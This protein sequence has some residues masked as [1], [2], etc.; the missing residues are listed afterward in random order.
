MAIH[1]S[2]LTPISDFFLLSEVM[3]MQQTGSV[4]HKLK[5]R[6]F[7]K[8]AHLW[9]HSVDFQ[10][11]INHAWHLIPLLQIL[12][13]TISHFSDY[14]AYL[15]NAPW[16]SRWTHQRGYSSPRSLPSTIHFG[17]TV[18]PVPGPSIVPMDNNPNWKDVLA[19]NSITNLT[20]NR[21]I[22]STHL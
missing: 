2:A 10:P 15:P 18:L 7:H 4:A 19:T 16:C 17:Q 22:S 12:F 3:T 8:S 14:L 5:L 1:Q 21:P 9:V 6:S 20:A 13:N 11:S